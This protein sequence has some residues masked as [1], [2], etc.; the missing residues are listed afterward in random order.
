[1]SL[2]CTHSCQTRLC[3]DA[4]TSRA[5]S[6]ASR[7][8]HT[9]ISRAFRVD[10]DPPATVVQLPSSLRQCI[11]LRQLAS[12]VSEFA[13]FVLASCTR[14]E[15][16]GDTAFNLSL[17]P[18][19]LWESYLGTLAKAEKCFDPYHMHVIGTECHSSLKLF[20]RM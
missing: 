4:P 7:L 18:P 10:R 17:Y 14:H 13:L 11:A 15:L 19:T 5:Y 2:Q 8:G 12:A 3:T 9:L 1:M 16:R 6:V 20:G